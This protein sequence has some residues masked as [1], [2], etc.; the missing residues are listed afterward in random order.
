MATTRLLP[1]AP[2]PSSLLLLLLLSC[3]AAVL[4]SVDLVPS[5]GPR[6]SSLLHRQQRSAGSS[7]TPDSY[8]AFIP[9]F[10]A[11]ALPG[12]PA[13]FATEC[14]GSVTATLR[15]VGRGAEL[16]VA[17]G[18]RPHGAPLLCQDGFFFAFVGGF[19]VAFY[20]VPHLAHRVHFTGNYT[21]AQ[22][23]DLQTL[24]VRV[25][26]FPRGFA[27]TAVDVVR[28][29]AMWAGY[30]TGHDMPAFSVEDNVRFMQSHMNYTMARRPV[31]RV[32]VDQSEFH[33]GDF[34]GIIRLDGLD[35]MLAWAMG[36]RTGHTALILEMAPGQLS[37]CESTTKHNYWPVDGI[38]CTPLARWL[39]MAEKAEYLVVHLPLAPEVRRAFDVPAAVKHVE[40]LLGLPYGFHNQFTGWIDTPEDNYPG[41]LSSQL[42]QIL[43]SIIEWLTRDVLRSGDSGDMFAG[44]MNKRLGTEGLGTAEVYREASL[45]GLSFTDLVTIPSNDSWTFRFADVGRE[46]PSMV[47]CVFVASVYK[48]AGILG[49]RADQI[50]ASEFTNW[51]VYSLDIFDRQWV[52]PEACQRADPDLPYC[53]LLGQYRMTLDGY[54]TATPFPHM[55]EKCPSKGPYYYRPADC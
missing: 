46:G 21:D 4:A 33:S 48:Q 47:C 8:F 14:F 54:S 1:L 36:S 52:R 32:D 41:A 30:L 10:R 18:R 51:D 53:Q 13:T 11:Q 31:T 2:V 17:L 49:P 24:G 40:S 39:D 27:G 50:M 29:A 6:W 42:V 5:E 35:P 26:Q 3:S 9:S 19:D 16:E 20:S 12:A 15:P 34:L 44:D 43:M 22:V 45:R 55:R 28:T 38:Q 25:F 7:A 37:V 23:Y